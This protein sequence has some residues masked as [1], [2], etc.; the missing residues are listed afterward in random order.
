MTDQ[1]KHCVEVC[2]T[3]IPL[4][5]MTPSAGNQITSPQRFGI[6]QIDHKILTSEQ[7]EATG[8]PAVLVMGDVSTRI[9]TAMKVESEDASTTAFGIYTQWVPHFGIPYLI[10]SDPKAN[11][12]SETMEM[13][14]YIIGVRDWQ[15]GAV[16]ASWHQGFVEHCNLTIG[17]AINQAYNRG[18]LST[19]R[20]L[21]MA[22]S[23][24]VTILNQH[25]SEAD[26]TSAF[27]RSTGQRPRTITD[28][29]TCSEDI[30]K[31][32]VPEGI[33]KIYVYALK[34]HTQDVLDMYQSKLEEKA[35]KLS[36]KGTRNRRQ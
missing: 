15:R 23:N 11:L 18:D 12:A 21:D 35:Q 1:V 4:L 24:A 9:V 5:Q 29:I 33:D 6:L 20:G 8:Y 14:T 2:E 22:V 30:I 34:A 7:A 26:G 36:G 13:L 19:S 28:V 31:V 27:Q 25:D 17:R 10:Q 32:A 3:C 16:G